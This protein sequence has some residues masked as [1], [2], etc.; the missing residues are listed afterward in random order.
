MMFLISLKIVDSAVCIVTFCSMI[1]QSY[2]LYFT[3]LPSDLIH[4]TS[5]IVCKNQKVFILF[6]FVHIYS[7]LC[8]QVLP[9]RRK[10][11]KLGLISER[12]VAV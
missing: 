1:L 6:C 3:H 9:M 10:R 2:K 8:I 12:R 7:Y 11:R 4:F 5:F